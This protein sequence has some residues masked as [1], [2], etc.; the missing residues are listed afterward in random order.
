LE[1]LYNLAENPGHGGGLLWGHYDLKKCAL[2]VEGWEKIPTSSHRHHSFQ[3]KEYHRKSKELRRKHT[4]VGEWHIHKD[5]PSL[6]EADHKT[7]KALRRGEWLIISPE[8]ACFYSWRGD[9]MHLK[10]EIHKW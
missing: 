6:V 3:W 7:M 4:I 2:V 5:S 9:Y 10:M 1:E 8:R